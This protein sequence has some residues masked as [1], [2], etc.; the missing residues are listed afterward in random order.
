MIDVTIF[1]GDPAKAAIV[2]AVLLG[3]GRLL[4]T[5]PPIPNTYI[6]GIL[7]LLGIV[8]YPV[9]ASV[10]TGE[11]FFIGAGAGLAAVG[12]HQNFVQAKEIVKSPD[13]KPTP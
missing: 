13:D 9:A 1:N 8:A 2:V 11:A 3:M 10:Y 4:K 6:P 12:L 7:F 5:I